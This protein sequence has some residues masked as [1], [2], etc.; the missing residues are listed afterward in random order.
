[1]NAESTDNDSCT[2]SNSLICASGYKCKQ[3]EKDYVSDGFP[4]DMVRTLPIFEINNVGYEYCDCI[5]S[6]S[7]PGGGLGMTGVECTTMFRRCPD[8]E[9]CFHGAS[10]V[11]GAEDNYF[12]DCSKFFSPDVM[13][14]GQHCEYQ[15]TDLCDTPEQYD[16]SASEQWMCANEGTCQSDVSIADTCDCPNGFEGLHCEFMS[17]TAPI[18]KLNCFNGGI[19]KIGVK[20]YDR[21]SPQ[22]RD[23]FEQSDGYDEHCICPEGFTGRQ[24][25]A[26]IN[27]CGRSH[28]LNGGE[29]GKTLKSS[30]N[31]YFYCNCRNATSSSTPEGT[32]I[33]FAGNACE[34]SSSVFCP[35]PPGFNKLDFYCTNGGACAENSWE[36]CICPADYSGPRC[37]FLVQYHTECDKQCKNGG[38]C[39]FGDEPTTTPYDDLD[40]EL[41]RVKQSSVNMHCKCSD[42]FIGYNCETK[43]EICGQSQHHCLNGGLCIDKNDNITD[44]TNEDRPG[45]VCFGGYRGEYCEVAPEAYIV[46]E[47]I[48]WVYLVILFLFTGTFLVCVCIK[49]HKTKTPTDNYHIAGATT[50]EEPE[51]EVIHTVIIT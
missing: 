6:S 25:E 31:E 29:C 39:I 37:E 16:V 1:V 27:D 4:A 33:K 21:V 34:S 32:E 40:I 14:T 35:A 17:E 8:N 26:S 15:V 42:V 10:C 7:V 11:K 13:F 5:E 28:C 9:I 30:G 48:M 45:C 46:A 51:E 18:C 38:T 36:G 3:G 49:L 47:Y 44:G 12:C 41:E 43:I 23:Y 22:L 2:G 50:P 20:N 19:C 24:C